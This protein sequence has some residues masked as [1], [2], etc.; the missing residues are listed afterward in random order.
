MTSGVSGS[1]N[2]MNFDWGNYKTPAE[3]FSEQ[4][5]TPKKES[6]FASLDTNKN[7]SVETNEA[8]AKIDA[9]LNVDE[10]NIKNSILSKY[11]DAVKNAVTLPNESVKNIYNK[12]A[13]NFKSISYNSNVSDSDLKTPYNSYQSQIDNEIENN[14]NSQIAGFNQQTSQEYSKLITDAMEAAK[15]ELAKVSEESPDAVNDGVFKDKDK[16]QITNEFNKNNGI[17]GDF[18]FEKDENGEVKS[19]TV[20][21]DK[22]GNNFTYIRNEDGQF[23]E[24]D[25]DGN[26]VKDKNGMLKSYTLTEDGNLERTNDTVKY[27]GQIFKRNEDGNY[28]NNGKTYFYDSESGK[29][30]RTI[31]L[32]EVVITEPKN[33]AKPLKLDM[34]NLSTEPPELDIK[35]IQGNRETTHAMLENQDA[36]FIT[37]EV[38]GEDQ[39]IAVYQNSEGEKVR[40][41]IN[42]DGSLENLV[43]ISTEGKNKYITQTEANKELTKLFGAEVADVLISQGATPVYEDGEI[44]A[45]KVGGKTMTGSELNSYIREQILSEKADIVDDVQNTIITPDN[46]IDMNNPPVYS[47]SGEKRAIKGKGIIGLYSFDE[48]ANSSYRLKTK[49]NITYEN[50]AF[51]AF[52]NGITN[53]FGLID[54]KP[55]SEGWYEFRGIKAK[56]INILQSMVRSEGQEFAGYTA[57]YNDLTMKQSQGI[58]LTKGEQAFM[59][60]YNNLLIKYNLQINDNGELEDLKK[61]K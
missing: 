32:P 38:N 47:I 4:A 19:I 30:T 1:D 25:K 17:E 6:I 40:Q 56:S 57:I 45:V 48:D 23:V 10:Q 36:K 52:K 13:S 12:F 34:P 21:S 26:Q 55:N 53:E 33:N 31:D 14:I 60:D 16:I 54:I 18:T 22:S 59:E 44:K 28:V 3:E 49:F 27:E 35:P 51:S 43:A 5:G 46:S 50:Q 8:K 29:M 41:I 11:A 42:D 24:V 15:A 9:G 61:K 58:T 2:N 37:R 20:K 39:E 7:S